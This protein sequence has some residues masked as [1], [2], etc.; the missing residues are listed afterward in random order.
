MQQFQNSSLFT[1]LFIAMFMLFMSF[2]TGLPNSSMTASLLLFGFS[3]CC[4]EF[5]NLGSKSIFGFPLQMFLP[6]LAT[7]M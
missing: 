6:S 1:L 5:E 7:V 2:V 4:M 3:A